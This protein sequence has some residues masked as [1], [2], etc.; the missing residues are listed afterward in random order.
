MLKKIL[1]V[2]LSIALV[3]SFSAC[4]K[5][6]TADTAPEGATG[7]SAASD[8]NEET[9]LSLTLDELEAYNGKDGMPAYVAVDGVIYDVTD[10]PQWADAM[11]FGFNA[12][13]D[14]SSDI[15]TKSPHGEK[16]LE[17]IPAVGKIVD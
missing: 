14:L 6:D 9:E 3:L 7:E 2:I 1:P 12:G 15:K 13:E 8:E 17:E 10:I 4:T 11:H 5:K 16:I